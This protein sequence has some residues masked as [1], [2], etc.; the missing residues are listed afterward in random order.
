[1]RT[2]QGPIPFR[3]PPRR[4]S[5]DR[6]PP[7]SLKRLFWITLISLFLFFTVFSA[8]AGF[9]TDL[10]W[11]E[12][13][14][15]S[16]VFWTTLWARAGTFVLGLGVAVLIVGG[17]LWL[18]RTLTAR[19]PVF[20]GQQM[21]WT[22]GAARLIVI[23]VTVFLGLSLAGMVGTQ[24]ENLLLFL[25][26]HSFGVADP[27]F[28]QDI[29]FYIFEL[30]LYHFVQTWLLG[31]LVLAILGVGAI[32]GLHRLPQIQHQI[33]ALPRYM[34]NHLAVLVALVAFD[35]A[36]GHWLS[37]FD[38]LYSERGVVFG[39][40][41]TDVN[42]SLLALNVL[43]PVAILVGLLTLATMVT[44]NL[45]PPAL[46]IG[47]WIVTGI[48]LGGVY[49]AIIQNYVVR[50]NEFVREQPFIEHNIK[51]TR[52][53]FRLE[54]IQEQDY[55]PQAL[56]A[57][58]LAEHNVTVQN[59]RL[60][61]Y[62]PLRQT[63]K[64]IQALRTYYDFDD[65]D[66]DRYQFEHGLQQVMLSARE[67][68]PTQLQNRT[69]VNEHLE[70]THGYGLVMSP[71]NQVR[72]EGLPVLYIQDLPPR[73]SVNLPITRPQ[74]YYGE[75]GS[76]YVF[77]RTRVQEFDY[78]KGDVNVRTTYE[79]KGGVPLDSFLKKLAF[80]YRFGDSE[81]LFAQ[82]LTPESRIMLYR[83]IREAAQ[84]IAP[85]LTYDRDPYL[86]VSDGRLI[87]LL[88]AY[89]TSGRYPYSQPVVSTGIRSL[90]GVNY[91]RNSVKV[92]IDAYDGTPTFYLAD[93][94]DPLITTW[95]AVFPGLF[96]SIDEMPASLRAHIRYPEDLF[97]V[98][99]QVYATYHMQ[100]A[101]VFYN[102]EDV[103]VIPTELQQ[104]N[105]A[106]PQEPYY[107]VIRLIGETQAEF[108]LT[109][110]FTPKGKDNLVAWMAARSDGDKYGGLVVYR[111]PKQEIIYGP[112]QILARINQDPLI[113]SQLS[114]WNQRG[115]QVIHGNLLI[116]PIGQSL[117]YVEPLYLQAE[118]SQ[119]PELKRI[120]VASGTEVRMEESLPR[121]LAGLVGAAPPVAAAAP[122][123][124]ATSSPPTS[125]S[126][127]VADLI[128]SAQSHYQRAQEALRAGNWAQYGEELNALGKDLQA[129]AE[130]IGQ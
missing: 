85:F 77:V 122:G 74:I 104:G 54:N 99:T 13:V 43:A 27:I 18:A 127:D 12:S 29:S 30:P 125:A 40:G 70:F 61:D 52:Q 123:Q 65:V 59:V 96:K 21:P 76:A 92:A 118:T 24:W 114:L 82:A 75:R 25:N 34:W 129:L 105:R 81:L 45:W 84:R 130:R 57:Q 32:Y 100:Q 38:L 35:L 5:D 46:G 42:A 58:L 16:S 126:T 119:I 47:L 17:N 55:T 68:D 83:G 91:I 89:T 95:A 23:I 20:F 71:V 67:L 113:S 15:F 28:S 86:V 94:S 78:P 101:N 69:W 108:L 2:N 121:A 115:S 50:P 36:L 79:G 26:R 10:L 111:F 3:R 102:R 41:Y 112:A 8:L 109:Q 14:G 37:R 48:L 66:I 33:Y 73:V 49:P 90:I 103:W 62:R 9:Y 93:P 4:D 106:L 39:A 124:P 31:V 63:F 97:S 128:R 7:G 87:W 22:G 1:M 6:R 56:N 72:G 44:R 110:V 120:I 51:F 64:Q 98:Q 19:E 116:I 53:A 11:F 80:S 117:L 107:V 88:D 60:W